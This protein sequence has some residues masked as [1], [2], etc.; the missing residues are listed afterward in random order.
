ME[1][2]PGGCCCPKDDILDVY[3]GDSLGFTNPCVQIPGGNVF[4]RV[5]SNKTAA[6]EWTITPTT[7]IIS[8]R[9]AISVA[10]QAE[11]VWMEYAR[12]QDGIN[13]LARFNIDNKTEEMTAASTFQRL[14]HSRILRATNTTTFGQIAFADSLVTHSHDLTVATNNGGSPQFFRIIQDPIDKMALRYWPKGSGRFV[15][16]GGVTFYIFDG[17]QVTGVPPNGTLS[18]LNKQTILQAAGISLVFNPTFTI[19]DQTPDGWAG[20]PA[21]RIEDTLHHVFMINGVE[22]EHITFAAS[23]LDP[24]TI[25]GIH[26]SHPHETIGPVVVVTRRVPGFNPTRSRFETYKMNGD[27]IWQSDTIVSPISCNHSSDRWLYCR[28]TRR[29]VEDMPGVVLETPGSGSFTYLIRHDG[30]ESV[31]ANQWV[32]SWL[33]TVD[34]LRN[35]KRFEFAPPLENFPGKACD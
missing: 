9:Q 15:S 30:S 31:P 12:P 23:N 7:P 29:S 16:G 5:T 3:W 11:I 20:V 33:P 24:P 25:T 22:K 34:V 6:V 18:V 14:A 32:Q 2:S 4:R 26:V 17:V 10:G 1:W 19:F 8:T 28:V 13:Q 27:L 35:S 21:Y